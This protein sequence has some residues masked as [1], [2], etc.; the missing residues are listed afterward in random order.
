MNWQVGVGAAPASGCGAVAVAAWDDNDGP[1]VH[2]NSSIGWSDM[3]ALY[4]GCFARGSDDLHAQIIMGPARRAKEP[5]THDCQIFGWTVSGARVSGLLPG[6][7]LLPPLPSP[8]SSRAQSLLAAMC[9]CGG[10]I[11]MVC[12]ISWSDRPHT[13]LP[14][15]HAGTFLAPCPL[16]LC[17]LLLSC[18]DCFTTDR[19]APRLMQLRPRLDPACDLGTRRVELCSSCRQLSLATGAVSHL[20]GLSRPGLSDFRDAY[21]SATTHRHWRSLTKL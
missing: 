12:A 11:R 16:N 21:L 10:T 20:G 17:P 6:G 3:N 18:A 9:W 14:Q 5:F 4:I 7:D 15:H 2:S 19:S 13:A 1:G 8:Y